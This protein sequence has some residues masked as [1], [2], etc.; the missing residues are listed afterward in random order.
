M[1]QTIALVLCTGLST[2]ALVLALVALRT[3]QVPWQ[4]IAMLQAETE[5]HAARLDQLDLRHKRL[6]ARVGM[7]QARE[8]RDEEPAALSQTNNETAMLPGETPQEWKRRMRLQ[9]AKRRMGDG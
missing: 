3:R 7:R 8:K 4:Q 9:L 5:D 1:W 2:A 6:N